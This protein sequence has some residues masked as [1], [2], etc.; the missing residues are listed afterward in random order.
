M[1]FTYRACCSNVTSLLPSDLE[2]GLH[3]GICVKVSTNCDV[4][5]WMLGSDLDSSEPIQRKTH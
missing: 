5:T 4:C 1:L 3:D 2:H